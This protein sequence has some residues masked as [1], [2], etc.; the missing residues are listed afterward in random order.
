MR[1]AEVTARAAL[2]VGAGMVLTISSLARA[3]GTGPS[4]H[5]RAVDYR[6][7]TTGRLRSV[8]QIY[9]ASFGTS[10]PALHLQETGP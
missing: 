2:E 3:E 7:V 8:Y 9:W 1:H 10:G 4:L 6:A 5:G